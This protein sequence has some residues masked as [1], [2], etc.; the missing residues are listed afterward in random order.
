M[1]VYVN[2]EEMK[3]THP[4]ANLNIDLD[5]I[6]RNPQSDAGFEGLTR[7]QGDCDIDDHCAAGLFCFQVNKATSFPPR[8]PTPPVPE[9]QAFSLGGGHLTGN[10]GAR[11]RSSNKMSESQKAPRV[12]SD[13]EEEKELTMR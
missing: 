2:G 10:A 6:G 3:W 7:C 8:A 9:G 1:E 13:S 4:N 11:S 12:H 5:Y